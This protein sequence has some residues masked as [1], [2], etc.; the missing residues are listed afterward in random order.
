MNKNKFSS[1]IGLIL[2]AVGS[3]VG[4]ANVWGFPYKFQD[5]G[6]VF[7]I[8]YVLFA[9]LFSYVGL[10]SEFAAGRLSQTGTLG[11]YEKIFMSEGKNKTLARFIGYLP[12]IGT[13]LI[14]I[15]YSVIVAYILKALVDS[16][17]GTL[18]TVDST[19]W[20]EGIS[21]NNYSV[22]PY[23]L[24]VIVATILTCIGGARTIEKTNKVLMPAFFILFLLLAIRVATLPGA[25]D[26]YKYM[27]RLDMSK[28]NLSTIIAAMGQAFFSLSI[29]GSG[30]IVVGAYIDKNVDIVS[31]SKQTG[32][33]DFI[34]AILSSCVMIP[35]LT[36]FGMDQV[37]G[38]GLL[39]VSL[40]TIMQNIE[41]GRILSVFL[42]LAVVFAGISSLQN[43]FEA[44]TESLT[45]RYKGL[46]RN[47]A[48]IGIAI[49]ALL[50]GVN[51]E[52]I[53]RFGPYMDYI[54]IYIIP[55]GASIGAITW[56]YV[57]A[58]DK[59]LSEINLASDRKYSG[60]WYKLGKYLYVPLAVILT[61]LALVF[62]ISF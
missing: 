61:V 30:M 40:P 15:G 11:A 62:K 44:V 41:L 49:I 56:F 54:S 26:G 3:A 25:I 13:F 38:P 33:Y 50:I 59:L 47:V 7:L 18:F 58:K 19:T 48:L 24:F 23:H 52:T 35:A 21:A 29:T 6:L 22:V 43:M 28:L 16:V 60:S 5:G 10:S 31:S 36:V 4:M 37:G 9:A 46:S 27:F 20:F 1:K 2:T 14:S 32:L 42:Y 55:I 34:A 8:F 57:L 51:M 12:L 45:F 53:D 39:F 17:T